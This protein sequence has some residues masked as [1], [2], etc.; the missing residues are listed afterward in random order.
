[1]IVVFSIAGAAALA[2][3]AYTQLR[4]RSPEVAAAGLRAVRELAAIVLVAVKAVEGV[5]DVLAGSRI[6]A[7]PATV[8]WGY[9]NYNEYDEEDER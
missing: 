3:I 1:M 5:T 6:Q 9:R 7:A 2:V 4:A 8:G